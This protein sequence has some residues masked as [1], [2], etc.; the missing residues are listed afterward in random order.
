MTAVVSVTS[1]EEARLSVPRSGSRIS[2]SLF[3]SLGLAE[4]TVVRDGEGWRW[5]RVSHLITT[6]QM[7]TSFF[8]PYLSNISAMVSPLNSRGLTQK[9]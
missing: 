3:L 2:F 8:P 6:S 9:F 5:S 4:R 1:C 7:L